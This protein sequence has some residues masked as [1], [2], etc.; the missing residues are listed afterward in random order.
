MPAVAR[1]WARYTG[2]D[3][4]AI[5]CV[6]DCRSKEYLKEVSK[7]VCKASD[8]ASWKPLEISQVM[9][10]FRRRRAFGVF[11][12]AFGERAEWQKAVRATRHE[13]SKCECGECN[14]RVESEFQA[15][16]G[17]QRSRRR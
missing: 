14:W 16:Y 6:K 15:E 5:I 3:D 8:L 7:Y 10:A 11:G 2:Q 1:A 17:S 13:R 12:R 9:D 4:N